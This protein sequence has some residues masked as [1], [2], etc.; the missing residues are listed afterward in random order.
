M[1][2][3]FWTARVLGVTYNCT[4]KESGR[5]GKAYYKRYYKR[6]YYGKNGSPYAQAEGMPMDIPH[7]EL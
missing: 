2:I 5:Y 6:G 4:D 1:I 3:S 7:V